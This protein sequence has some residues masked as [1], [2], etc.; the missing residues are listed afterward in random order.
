MLEKVDD[1]SILLQQREASECLELSSGHVVP[2]LW[3]LQSQM[4][5]QP[6]QILLPVGVGV[7]IVSGD[8]G[9]SPQLKIVL[10]VNRIQSLQQ[11]T[12]VLL[13]QLISSAEFHIF[14]GHSVPVFWPFD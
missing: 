13:K 5:N 6:V 2:L 12:A 4:S 7:P 14:C 11:R 10:R 8:L 1:S 9:E 3:S